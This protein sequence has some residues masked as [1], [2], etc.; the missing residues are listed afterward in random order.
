MTLCM[1]VMLY[2]LNTDVTYTS[3]TQLLIQH[4]L[5][6]LT[7]HEAISHIHKNFSCRFDQP[8][9]SGGEMAVLQALTNT[10]GPGIWLNTIVALTHAG[11]LPPS[12]A[13]GQ[14]SYDSYA[15]QRSHLLQLIIRNAS[16]D[17]RLMN[18]TAFV[19]SHPD[20]RTNPEVGHLCACVCKLDMLVNEAAEVTLCYLLRLNVWSSD[21]QVGGDICCSSNSC[22]G[23][24]S[25]YLQYSQVSSVP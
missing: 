13:R 7:L 23:T 15:Q 21:I 1:V 5:L 22:F 24:C 17:A 19:E 4:A 10:L 9:R 25:C 3:A 11:G 6:A 16:G 18:P 20:C 14:L 8:S 12:T 2:M